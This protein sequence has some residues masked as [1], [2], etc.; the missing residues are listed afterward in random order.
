M[1]NRRSRLITN[2]N[3]DIYDTRVKR[4]NIINHIED[5]VNLSDYCDLIESVRLNKTHG[6]FCMNDNK[7]IICVSEYWTHICG[8]RESEISGLKPTFL[9]G[10]ET[11]LNMIKIF[12]NSLN[13]NGMSQTNIINYTKDG[14]QFHNNLSAIKLNNKYETN[15]NAPMFVAEISYF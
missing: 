5:F 8:Y 7:E 3:M 15:I 1:V 12:E 14:K 2:I 4:E 6:F 9:Q 13:E 10:E 11:N